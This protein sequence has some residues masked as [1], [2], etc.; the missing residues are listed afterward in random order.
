MQEFICV[1]SLKKQLRS[2]SEKQITEVDKIRKCLRIQ[3][4]MIKGILTLYS[5]NEIRTIGLSESKKL[6]ENNKSQS[7]QLIHATPSPYLT[8]T[9]C[10]NSNK[11]GMFDK[12]L[13]YKKPKKSVGAIEKVNVSIFQHRPR[14]NTSYVEVKQYKPQRPYDI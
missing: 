14:L 8:S 10:I 2:S 6:A 7:V 9:L 3:K 5:K 1:N 11:V 4:E 12:T 13:E